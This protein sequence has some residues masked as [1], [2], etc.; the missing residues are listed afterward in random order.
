LP[1]PTD[2]NVLVGIATS[3]DAGVYRLTDEIALVQTVDF[4]TPVVDDPFDFG[5]IAAANSLSDIYAMGAT[6]RTALNVATFPVEAMG[7][8]I[9][10][11]ILS[12]GAAMARLAGVSIIGGHTV[13]DDEPKYGLAVTGTVHPDKI[14]TNA[15]ARAG[16]IVFLT[17]AIGTGVLST[18]LKKDAI[19]EH[20]MAPAIASMTTLNEG[21]SRAM[22][23]VGVHAATDVTGYG[24]LGHAVE[25][26]NASRV[27]LRITASRVPIFARV[28]DLIADDVMP[29]GTKN[30]ARDHAT[31]T[32][33]A[34]GVPEAMR[35][36]LSDAQTSGGLLIAV[37]PER[38]DALRDALLEN[39]ALAAEIG[40]F[41]PGT[42]I[43]VV[44]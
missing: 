18:A 38:A 41:E 29:G 32:T 2:P 4:F 34:H 13:E 21:A 9:L 43:A 19:D 7:G 42:G 24:V 14:V 17:K 15:G 44:E 6:P 31:F 35:L 20:A 27:R 33:F 3:D 22:V 1:Q 8:A 25:M 36:V 28:L 11:Q 39:G 16:D 37:P 5:R 26:A 40:E 23:A 10:A 12:G 30:N